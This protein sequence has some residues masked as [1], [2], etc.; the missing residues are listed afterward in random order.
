MEKVGKVKR[1]RIDPISIVFVVK[2]E[3]VK[4]DWSII[5]HERDLAI[6]GKRENEMSFGQRYIYRNAD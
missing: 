6:P 2:R 3:N 4:S 1:D 5:L